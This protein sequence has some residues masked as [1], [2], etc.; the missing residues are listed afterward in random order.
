M[1]QYKKQSICEDCVF[2]DACHMWAED[3]D[4]DNYANTHGCERNSPKSEWVHLPCKAGD[5]VYLPWE[6]HGTSGIALLRILWVTLAENETFISTVNTNLEND[7][8]DYI[9]KYSFV[10]FGFEDFGSRV[11]YTV[12]EAEKALAERRGK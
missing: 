6:W 10:R 3:D 8:Y 12:E 11:F 9:M 5:T 2:T 4:A 1:T 7:D